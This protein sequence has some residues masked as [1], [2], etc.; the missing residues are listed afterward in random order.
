MPRIEA[1]DEIS[2]RC[3]APWARNSSIAASHWACAPSTLVAASARLA[4]ALPV[5]IDAPL[6]M[7]ALTMHAVEPAEPVGQLGDDA[8]RPPSG[9]STSSRRRLDPDA[10]VGGEQLLLQRLEPVGAAGGERQ[11]AAH[12]GEP[13]G[14]ALAEAGAGAGDQDAL[15][16]GV[17]H[18]VSMPHARWP[19]QRQRASE[20][21]G[22]GISVSG[23]R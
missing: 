2:T 10:G 20:R 23:G 4:H 14:H 21:R 7:P 17:R 5:P 3:P 16:D 19:R 18:R 15:A 1:T 11:V 8:W 9:S 12:G 6:P 22:R 13:A